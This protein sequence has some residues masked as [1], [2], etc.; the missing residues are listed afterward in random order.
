MAPLRKLGVQFTPEVVDREKWNAFWDAPLMVPGLPNS[1]WDLPRKPEE[2]RRAWAT[3]NASSCSVKTDGARIEVEFP[4]LTMGI[5][6]GGLRY[7]VYKGTNLLRQEAIAKTDEPSVAYIYVAGLKGLAISNDTKVV[8]RDTARAWQQ[9]ALGGGVNSDPVA[10]K[11]RNR[12]AIVESGG[13]S[14][15][16]L[17]PP[18][19]FFFARELETNLGYVYYR[20]DSENSF[21]IGA[22]QA[23]R[24]EP[25]KP[26]GVSDEVWNRRA[27]ESR[28]F[29]YNFALYNAPPG[30][31]S[32]CPSI[33]I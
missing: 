13:G 3:Y 18:H 32:T 25:Y 1:S 7:T 28:H 24:E 14:L 2:I 33:F 21:A 29:T 20:K 16:F 9:C 30:L 23:E 27:D 6:S 22:R 5:F 17:P 8:W 4:G 15:A 10:L 11:A 26:Y 31:G 19:K 12:L